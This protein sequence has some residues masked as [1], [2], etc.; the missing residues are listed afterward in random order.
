MDAS[1]FSA[2]FCRERH[3]RIEQQLGEVKEW[4]DKMGK[5][6]S[7]NGNPEKGL[8]HQAYENT[9]FRKRMEDFIW[10]MNR[11]MWGAVVAIIVSGLGMMGIMAKF[12][13]GFAK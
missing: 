2:D 6:I 13:S 12:L 8:V 5:I 4:Q 1:Q 11:K 3:Q 7:G 10:S 9:E